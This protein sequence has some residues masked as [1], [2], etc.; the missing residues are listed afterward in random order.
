MYYSKHEKYPQQD[1]TKTVS[2]TTSTTQQQ[3]QQQKFPKS[4]CQQEHLLLTVNPFHTTTITS[5]TTAAADWCTYYYYSWFPFWGWGCAPLPTPHDTRAPTKKQ[6][7]C[8]KNYYNKIQQSFLRISLDPSCPYSPQKY[9]SDC[10][11]F[12][13]W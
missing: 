9:C 8:K 11:I 7:S 4:R 6:F 1:T 5:T 12:W 3:Q 10:S 13:L 2:T